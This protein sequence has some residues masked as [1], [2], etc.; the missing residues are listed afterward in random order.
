MALIE[1]VH[2]HGQLGLK[3][4]PAKKEHSRA[5]SPTPVTTGQKATRRRNELGDRARD[6]YYASDSQK[7]QYFAKR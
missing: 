5:A 2:H 4:P 7:A 6:I 1:R 3:S